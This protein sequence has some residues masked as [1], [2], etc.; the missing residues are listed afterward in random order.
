MK[1][2]GRLS[3]LGL[4]AVA[5]VLLTGCGVRQSDV[6]EAGGP[7]TVTV[8]P[9]AEQRQI[10]FFVSSEGRLTPVAGGVFLDRKGEYDG[11]VPGETALMMLFAGPSAKVRAAGLH[12]ELPRAVGQLGMK[13]GTDQVLVRV[14]IAVR[15]LGKTAVRQLV[16]T[17]AFA[18][19]GDGTAEVTIAGDDGELPPAHCDV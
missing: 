3:R 17:A 18:E 11:K 1:R 2:L 8:F 9:D 15:R 13:S 10:L 4:P 19:G 14:P 7:A 12:T 5:A 6:I 16:C